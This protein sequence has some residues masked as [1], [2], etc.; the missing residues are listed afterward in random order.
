[1]DF[2]KLFVE[3]LSS[4]K[5]NASKATIKNYRA[6]VGKF[7]RWFET[8]FRKPFNSKDITPQLIEVY[9]KSRVQYL[10]SSQEKLSPRSLER[11][12]SSLRK[13]LHFLK[14]EGIISKNP[15]ETI[16]NSLKN[17][18]LNKDKWHLNQFKNYLYIY[19]SAHL[20][21]KNYTIDVKQFFCWLEQVT[22][23]NNAWDVRK[24]NVFEKV[25]PMLINEYKERLLAQNFSPK[26]INRKLSSLRKYLA[27]AQEEKLIKSE[28]QDLQIKNEKLET[29]VVQPLQDLRRHAVRQLTD[30]ASPN[31]PEINSGQPL[32]S[33]I[34]NP[35]AVTPTRYSRLP[36]L[37][38]LQKTTNGVIFILDS[39][40]VL[41][42]AKAI[43]QAKYLFWN[44]KGK[45]VFNQI[46]SKS[47]DRQGNKS[48]KGLIENYHKAMY[49]PLFISTA[50]FPLHKKVWHHVRHTRPKWYKRY[51]SYAVVHYLHFAILVILM[52]AI[53]F[54]LYNEFV[55]SAQGKGEANAF[56][57]SQPRILAFKGRLTDSL[58]NPIINAMK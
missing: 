14:I 19:N 40:L 54:A 18:S 1:M 8:E 24:R 37:R 51:H 21:I 22:G 57:N 2:L 39:L 3:Y 20:T 11:H 27:W 47:Q 34:L 58:D 46:S 53:G 4:Q 31:I 43:E 10:S 41:P 32:K 52:S 50:Y 30:S 29:R 36:P 45:P 6:D 55:T 49:A 38:L 15:F 28:W 9:K 13:F 17:A 23:I 42:L 25:N 48:N 44:I 7:I 33:K 56:Q 5:N 35:L 16:S 26:T 12:L